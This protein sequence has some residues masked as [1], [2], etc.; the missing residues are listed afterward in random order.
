MKHSLL[1]LAFVCT[2]ATA[3][4]TAGGGHSG[5]PSGAPAGSTGPSSGTGAPLTDGPKIKADPNWPPGA[6]SK[7]VDGKC[8]STLSHQYGK[9]VECQ[10]L[11]RKPGS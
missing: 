5:G 4:G 9:L 7:G 3:H 11:E 1:L 2:F 10:P 6:V 8:R